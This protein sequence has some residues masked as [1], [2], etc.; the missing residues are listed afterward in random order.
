M[1]ESELD[2]GLSCPKT[3]TRIYRV[4][5]NSGNTATCTQAVTVDDNVNPVV[6]L[7]GAA[8]MELCQGEV[9]VDPGA[10]A[11]DNCSGNLSVN[12]VVTG[13]VNTAAAAVYQLE[14]TAT[15]ACGNVH[16]QTRTVTVNANP[17]VTGVITNVSC[18]GG[19]N[20]AINI[21]AAGGTPGYTYNWDGPGVV[22]ANEDQTNLPGGTYL[23]TV[24]DSEGC[25]VT[26]AFGITEPTELQVSINSQ[27]NVDCNGE[28]TGAATVSASGG[29]APYEYDWTGNPTGDGTASVSDL[30]AGTYTVT[31]T[32]DNDCTATVSVT[33]T[34]P[35]LL[36]AE[37][38]SQTSETCAGGF[39]GGATVNATG[40]ATPYTYDWSNDGPDDPDDDT[41]T[42][43]FLTAGT[44]T[45]TV[46]DANDCTATAEVTIGSG[47]A[48]PD[49]AL[50]A[51]GPEGAVCGA[52]ISVRI[53]VQQFVSIGSLQFSV[54]WD[55]TE[56]QLLS[57]PALAIDGDMPVIGTPAT[58][59]LT[60]SWAD[61]DFAPYG[62]GLADGTT[63]L[64]M[65]FKVLSNMTTD[66][67]VTITGVPT[68]IEAST[69]D[70]CPVNVA[71]FNEVDFDV[72]KITVDCPDNVTTCLETP[73][74]TLPDGT[75]AGGTFS[76]TGVVNIDEFDPAVAGAGVHVITYTGTDANGCS[77]TCTFTV[78][79][80]DV[81]INPIANVGPVC[82]GATVPAILLSAIPNDP[83]IAYSWSGG[84]GAGLANGNSTGL[85]P[86]IPSFTAG[87]TEGTWTVTVTATLGACTDTEEFEITID[88]AGGLHWVNCPADMTVNNDVD[89]CGANINWTPPT[90]LDDCDDATVTGPTGG[91]PGSFFGV[92][93]HTITYE[94]T[95]GNGNTITC[96]FT[97]T[98]VDMQLPD[99][100]CKDITVALVGNSVNITAA[101]VDNSSSDNCPGMTLGIN[102]GSFSCATSAKTS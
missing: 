39:D 60:Y 55:D 53:E 61:A 48:V 62:A 80:I 87:A 43:S 91:T 2:N 81:E 41:N 86:A 83:A 64:T 1:L 15:D 95:D 47:L 101:N 92:G 46:T 21:T 37:I 25:S 51:I 9:F 33:I 10:T 17:T 88:D 89:K 73:A 30:A 27:T 3:I 77:N 63:I 82:P 68:T 7:L 26:E 44:Y 85:N 66:V 70:F 14:Y 12:I 90:A 72:D 19:S 99:A 52:E 13:S 8:S 96:S 42:A 54:N 4:A 102:N 71:V 24:T 56:L 22:A 59:Q 5:D 34:E 36:I 97:I 57:N 35:T 78:T 16:T 74:F 84:A 28:A 65:T 23:V 32:D 100:V 45:V 20:G 40:G 69:G 67:N 49:L 18:H 38:I 58:D 50:T 11:D 75:P 94:A 98:V 76:G 29:T 31:V 93:M 79:V 6:T